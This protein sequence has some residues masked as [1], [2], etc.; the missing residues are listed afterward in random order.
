MNNAPRECPKCKSTNIRHEGMASGD[1]GYAEI[2]S[3]KD[4]T[5]TWYSVYSYSHQE[6]EEGNILSK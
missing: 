5:L 4:C 2:E 3:C 1:K 6:D